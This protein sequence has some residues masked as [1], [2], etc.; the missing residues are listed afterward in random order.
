MED[1]WSEMAQ[2]WLSDG[3]IPD[4]ST[5]IFRSSAAMAGELATFADSTGMQVKVPAGRL[6]IKGH[7]GRLAAQTT[8]TLS[9]AHA[10]LARIDSVIAQLDKSGNAIN[11]T[12]STGT[13]AGS[14][15]APGLTQNDTTY[16]IRLANI[17]VA[18]AASTIAAGNVTDTRT[19]ALP[20]GQ[21]VHAKMSTAGTVL[22][23]GVASCANPATGRFVLVWQTAF[24]DANYTILASAQAGAFVCAVVHD[25]SVATTGCE[26]RVYDAAGVLA[27]PNWVHVTAYA[28]D[29]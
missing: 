6:W 13:P 12:I 8:L 4:R 3:V 17:A 25:G 7:L 22:G 21:G 20:R 24:P 15:A 18:A 19:W 9:A 2:F 26:I 14:P 27:A 10:T 28:T 11:L 16:E 5:D 23:I 29:L 1:R